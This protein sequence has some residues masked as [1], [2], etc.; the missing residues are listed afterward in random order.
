LAGKSRLSYKWLILPVITVI[1]GY[2]YFV[3]LDDTI[4]FAVTVDN[5]GFNC[6]IWGSVDDIDVKN[7]KTT[8]GQQTVNFKP[9]ITFSII[10][11][12]SGNE[13]KLLN[14][15][16]NLQCSAVTGV[17]K[18][19]T[20]NLVGG[21][22]T[23]FW[24]GI[25]GNG[26]QKLIK[27]VIQDIPSTERSALTKV[28]L[29]Q[30]SLSASEINAKITSSKSTYITKITAYTD[31]ELKFRGS[32][33]VNK[34]QTT[35]QTIS[36]SIPEKLFNEKFIPEKP[37]NQVVKL[38]S[39]SPSVININDYTNKG[40]I[41]I[42][43]TGT[44]EQ[45]RESEGVP[46]AEIYQPDR[47]LFA[48]IPLNI[49]KLISP[50]TSIWEFRAISINIP[51]NAQLGTWQII[52]HS[53]NDVRKNQLGNPSADIR[54][55]LVKN[56]SPIPLSPTTPDPLIPASD[57][58][59]S[60]KSFIA[61]EINLEGGSISGVLPKVELFD[62]SIIPKATLTGE[63]QGTDKRV[64]ELQLRPQIDFTSVSQ[65]I[66]P[67]N[68]KFDHTYDLLVNGVEK[69][70][71]SK[72]TSRQLS[73]S[74]IM[75]TTK[76]YQISYISINPI[77]MIKKIQE[78]EPVFVLNDGD[79]VTFLMKISGS[80]DIDV[81]GK[82]ST[83]GISG[84]TYSYDM[85]N[86]ENID[87]DPCKG[88]SGQPAID[89][90]GK[91]VPEPSQCEA[92]LIAK[93][94]RDNEYACVDPRSSSGECEGLTSAECIALYPQSQSYDFYKA[95]LDALTNKNNQTYGNPSGTGGTVGFCGDSTTP[96]DCINYLKS[97]IGSGTSFVV[98]TTFVVALIVIIT[99][100]IIIALIIRSRRR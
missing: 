3:G 100:I 4:P 12:Q 50:T 98:N 94:I 26:E 22:A 1:I 16:G 5:Q 81:N 58:D 60:L 72:F 69:I 10:S 68:A 32:G 8:Y 64:V 19:L 93:F 74:N 43:I 83:I 97:L 91:T 76:Y 66:I 13:L 9:S 55:F 84:M 47:S 53:N 34:I 20:M 59:I 82:E 80:M 86:I 37:L 45:W 38:S 30:N 62:V 31:Y 89:C 46:F 48:K 85:I 25:D 41:T 73:L 44:L 39:I 17:P 79:T 99:M 36:I 57:P 75:T 27:T 11:M 2:F 7:Q 33:T 49:K 95:L 96:D 14:T 51:E 15:N 88:L 28:T 6:K 23:T 63:L 71:D 92:P 18:T 54:T 90:K 29:P 21:R 78:N 56:T 42:D 35:K 61:Y 67:S 52:M 77:E 40:R 65:K 87:D 70:K 24:Y